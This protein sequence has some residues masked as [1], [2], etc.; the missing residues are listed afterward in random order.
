[1]QYGAPVDA[2][3]II[4]TAGSKAAIFMATMAALNPGDDALIHEPA[5]LSYPAHVKLARGTPHFIPYDKTPEE[6]EQYFTPNTKLLII[7]TPNNPGGHV[8]SREALEKI[9]RLCQKRGA[10]LMV[11]EAYSDFVLD[12]FVSAASIAP[13]KENLIIANSLSKNMGMSGWRVGYT[14]SSPKMNV[15]LQKLNQHIISCAPTILTHYM[16]RYFDDVI[17]HTLPQVREV[18]EKRKR[19]ADYMDSIG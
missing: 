1:E 5:W 10:W 13:D 14:I 11:D 18:V 15:I 19:I 8:Y 7:C 2:A 3:D 12:S 4:I 6:F 17:A 9:Y 16:E